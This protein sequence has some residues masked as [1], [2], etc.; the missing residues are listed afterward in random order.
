MAIVAGD[1][2]RITPEIVENISTSD[3]HAGQTLIKM[4]NRKVQ[5]LKYT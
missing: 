3:I 5:N 1:S 4:Y 2:V